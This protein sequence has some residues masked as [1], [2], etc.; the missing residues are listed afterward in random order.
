MEFLKVSFGFPVSI[1]VEKLVIQSS[2]LSYNI[3]IMIIGYIV[4]DVT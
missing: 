2:T 4:I 3:N 1:D